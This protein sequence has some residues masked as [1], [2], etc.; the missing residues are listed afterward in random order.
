[1]VAD[2]AP[3][4]TATTATFKPNYI[5]LG[6][7][8]GS[9]L[10]PSQRPNS[11]SPQGGYQFATTYYTATDLQDAYGVSS[12]QSAGYD[13]RGETIA[14]IDAYGD[15]TINQ[16]VAA[17]DM[18]FGLPSASLSIIPV[19]P[20]EPS[21]GITYGW[22]AETALDVEAAH[23]MAPYAHINLLIA[24]NASNAL[25]EAVK[26]AVDNH[27]GDVVSMSWGLAESLYGESGFS[28]AGFLNYPYL[29]YY[30]QKGT[31]LGM[32]FFVASGDNGAYDGT[33]SVTGS[34]PA[35][36][37]FVTAVG[38]TSLFLTPSAGYVSDLNSSA[39]YQGE[40]AW[41][42]SPQYVGTPGVSSGGGYSDFF[43]QPYYQAD[44]IDSQ[45]RS[46]PDVAA[47]A[48]PYTGLVI[49]LEGGTYAI[50]GTSLATPLWAGMGADLDQ[51]VGRD[52][53]LLNPDLYSIYG[54]K[55]EYDNAFHQITSGFNG[56]YEAGSG[57]N[58]VTGLGTPNLPVLAADIKNQV[59]GLTITVDTSQGPSASAPTQYS[60]GDTITMAATARNSQGMPV[61]TGTFNAN[62]ASVQGE[63]ASVPLSFN[64]SAWVG[65]YE[66]KPTDPYNSWTISVTGSSG[67]IS[68]EGI[69]DVSVGASLGILSPVPYPYASPIPPNQSFYIIVSAA[70]PDGAVVSNANLTAYLLYGGKLVSNVPLSPT[71]GGTYVASAKIKTGQPQGT[72]V[73]VVNEPSFGSVYSYVFIGEGVV[74]VMETPNDDAIPSAAPG[75][76][77]TFLARTI[78]SAD[79]GAFTSNATADIYSLSG[80][81]EASVVLQPAPNAVQF[82]VFNF[83]GYQQANFTIPANL[84]PG[85]YKLQFLSSYAGNSTAGVQL[86]N[87]TTGFYVSGPTLSYTVSN[88][89]TV[90]E[91]QDV[92][93]LANITDSTGAPVTTG[94]FMATIIPSG[95]AY[96]SFLTDYYAYT[97]V[98]MQYSPILG[99]WVGLFRIPS[100]LTSPNY[101]IGND[102][103]LGSGPWTVFV[104][105]ESGN[106]T[107]AATSSSYVDVLPYTFYTTNSLSAPSIGSAPLVSFNGTSYAL[108]NIGSANLTITGLNISLSSD[109]IGSL[110]LVNSN[111]QLD[112]TQVGSVTANDSTLSLLGGTHVGT[113]TLASTLLTVVS[114]SYDHLSPGFPTISVSGLA[115][116]VTNSTTFTVTVSGEQL[117]NGSLSATIDGT[118]VSLTISSS[119]STGVTATGEVN[120][121]SLADG[122]HTLVLRIGQ[123]DGMSTSFSTA[124]SSNAHE[125]ALSTTVSAVQAEAGLAFNV[126][127]GLA[128]VA[129]AALVIAIWALQ[130][131]APREAAPSGTAGV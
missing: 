3:S 127:Y 117:L 63:V 78:T 22:D 6:Q 41:S 49:V 96:E 55:S 33:Y 64:G 12:L 76:L 73:L 30:L 66:V 10:F 48:N 53:G 43:A 118:A 79:T 42:I 101:F 23:A 107:N 5:I 62:I 40:S 123:S 44:A 85:F 19:G 88:P 14:I 105:G 65:T 7:I 34:F 1:V 26:M 69:G 21:L 37:P 82:G 52:L 46:F 2:S 100:V 35:S 32:S 45:T 77:V 121:N 57:Y 129:V 60:Y 99:E 106:A 125:S 104:E 86:G 112:G 54:N 124:F 87:F 31:S 56:E 90:F 20:Y 67:G 95:Y 59:Q 109:S 70:D 15:P 102:L 83:F 51:F 27:L 128:V 91:G 39:T 92:R 108:N 13:G 81:L 84:P 18:M 114:S 74:G 17:F 126:A 4:S 61:A 110:T 28:A 72:Y 75:Q 97:G 50:G 11:V 119:S 93:V 16:D 89:A 103:T 71:G 115:T 122:V 94:V 116:P 9:S 111:V 36:S 58:L 130:R 29:D 80:V 120:G 47:D 113:L 98:P 24:A 131:K 68:G 38:G 8:R 25:F